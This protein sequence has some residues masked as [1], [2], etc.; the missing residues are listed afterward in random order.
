MRAE[1][2]RRI[3][4]ALVIMALTSP[5]MAGQKFDRVFA[6]FQGGA[7]VLPSDL[8]GES[9][10]AGYCIH[11]SDEVDEVDDA[12]IALRYLDDPVMGSSLRSLH[13]QTL[14]SSNF[15]L[16]MDEVAARAEVD[17]IDSSIWNVGVWTEGELYTQNSARRQTIVRK[18]ISPGINGAYYVAAKRCRS[19]DGVKCNG[20]GTQA[21]IVYEACYFYS[22]K[23]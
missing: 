14:G 13:Q 3:A 23:F 12:M 22:R 20:S 21:F 1:M 8:S 11:A 17:K 16:R 9:A 7:P 5:V 18:A 10:W 19:L 6:V 4:F 2:M 15:Y